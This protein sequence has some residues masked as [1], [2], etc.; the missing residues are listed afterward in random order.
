LYREKVHNFL[1][2]QVVL[3]D[4]A[5]SNV[6]NK[7]GANITTVRC[8]VEFSKSDFDLKIDVNTKTALKQTSKIKTRASVPSHIKNKDIEDYGHQV[9]QMF[10]YKISSLSTPQCVKFHRNANDL[11]AGVFN[12]PYPAVDTNYDPYLFFDNNTKG[13]GTRKEFSTM[14]ALDDYVQR[15]QAQGLKNDVQQRIGTLGEEFL[16]GEIHHH[17]YIIANEGAGKSY[18]LLKL[19]SLYN[20]IYVCHTKKKITETAQTLKQLSIEYKII[21]GVE[22]I[23]T[24]NGHKHL[25]GKYK[26]YAKKTTKP[27]FREFVSLSSLPQSLIEAYDDNNNQV[28]QDCIVLMTSAKLKIMMTI[29]QGSIFGD[30]KPIIFDEFLVGEWYRDFLTDVKPFSYE[31]T[32][33]STWNEG[34]KFYAT[35]VESFFELLEHKSVLILTT[36]KRLISTMMFGSD[37]KEFLGTQNFSLSS[38][39]QLIDKEPI[40]FKL[41]TDNVTYL[42]VKSTRKDI[43]EAQIK[44]IQGD[45]KSVVV[46]SNGVKSTI[47]NSL[48]HR[49][50]KGINNLSQND[51]LIIGTLKNEQQVKEYIL[52]NKNYFERMFKSQ[53]MQRLKVFK[54]TCTSDLEILESYGNDLLYEFSEPI[55]QEILLETEVS[56]SIGRNSGFRANGARCVV[57]LPLIQNNTFRRIARRTNLNYISK[58]VKVLD[59]DEATSSFKRVS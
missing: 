56:Q 53:L 19:G 37:Y 21:V 11:G 7:N 48:T 40:E 54:E 46:I 49:G 4:G 15:Q 23:L 30:K 55:V 29:N 16:Y 58:N 42:L 27:S 32:V 44:E 38:D 6:N 59:Y 45:D 1:F 52:N 24:D 57:L 47:T 28:T 8:E 25:I 43:L 34:S 10:G 31:F 2:P 26:Q 13:N 3:D 39:Y 50:I 51:T 12:V 41:E 9:N 17:M 18:S 33:D 35:E 5:K 20:F 22:D 36:E 14:F